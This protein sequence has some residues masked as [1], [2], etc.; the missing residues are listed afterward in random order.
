MGNS[1]GSRAPI[2][3]RRR[4]LDPHGESISTRA[5]GVAGGFRCIIIAG[6]PVLI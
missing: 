4:R 6:R 1:Q 5:G 3:R 2:A